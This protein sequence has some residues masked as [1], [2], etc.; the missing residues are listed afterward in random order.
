MIKFYG[1]S[2]FSLNS[3][4]IFYC[5]LLSLER[6]TYSLNLLQKRI[7]KTSLIK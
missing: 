7:K 5:F 2:Y 6:K 3:L 4:L 1:N